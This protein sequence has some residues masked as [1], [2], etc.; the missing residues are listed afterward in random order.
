MIEFEDTKNLKMFLFTGADNFLL[1]FF[2]TFYNARII[3]F[4]IPICFRL[5]AYIDVMHSFYYK[6]S[7]Y[8][9]RKRFL[10]GLLQK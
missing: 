9:D 1:F 3:D 4:H 6:Y 7:I 5:L 2:Y 8:H 10:P